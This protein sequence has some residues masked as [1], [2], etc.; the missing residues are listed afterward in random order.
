MRRVF[1]AASVLVA[2]ACRDDPTRL[3]APK[4]QVDTLSARDFARFL[5]KDPLLLRVAGLAGRPELALR[6]DEMVLALDDPS[7]RLM[8]AAGGFDVSRFRP[9]FSVVD[10]SASAADSTAIAEEAIYA[11][12]LEL[13]AERLI[14]LASRPDSTM[15]PLNSSTNLRRNTP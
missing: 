3:L 9:V 7:G 11:A 5:Y 10:T 4:L 8:L 13:T 12:V 1:L 6:L 2:V 14:D 15:T